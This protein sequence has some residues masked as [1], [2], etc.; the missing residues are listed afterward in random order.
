MF[1]DTLAIAYRI[2]LRHWYVRQFASQQRR[3]TD[4]AL[5]TAGAPEMVGEERVEATTGG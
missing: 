4:L 5:E 1:V 2:H 3:R